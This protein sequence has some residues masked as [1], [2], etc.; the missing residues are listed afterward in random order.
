MTPPL[1]L[2]IDAGG[3]HCRARLVDAAGGV[4]GTGQAGPANL[5]LGIDRA[6]EA[7]MTASARAFAT[8][9]LASAAA[10]RTHAGMGI[11]GI[12]DPRLARAIA[13]SASGSPP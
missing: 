2:G 3:T 12:D 1:F 10:R 9:G 13:R 5:T 4:L 11:A 8:A 7:I 6:H